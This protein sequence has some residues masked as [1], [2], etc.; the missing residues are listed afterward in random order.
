MGPQL[1]NGIGNP[2]PVGPQLAVASPFNDIQML[3]MVAALT[4]LADPAGAVDRAIEI[5]AHAAA[6]NKTGKLV[7]RMRAVIREAT[8]G[9]ADH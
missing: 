3:A 9:N 5:V 8:E 6:A 2:A 4:G 7:E 1:L